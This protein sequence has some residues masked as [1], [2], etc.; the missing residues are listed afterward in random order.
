MNAQ[1]LIFDRFIAPL[2]ERAR[3]LTS[4][5]GCLLQNEIKKVIL[6]YAKL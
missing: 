2:F 1:K 6:E 5:S 3:T 4:P